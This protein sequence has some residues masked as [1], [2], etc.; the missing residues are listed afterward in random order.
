MPFYFK[1]KKISYFLNL[2]VDGFLLFA[3]FFLIYFTKRGHIHIEPTFINFIPV[4]ILSW[5]IS[6]IAGRKFKSTG[7]DALFTH[8]KPYILSIF[9]QIGLLSIILY[10]FKWY[11]LSR[12]IIFGSLGVFFLTEIFLLSG[13]YIYPF[14][15]KKGKSVE[16]NFSFY[17]FLLEFLL[18]TATFLGV[19]F[20]KRG[21]IELSDDYKAIFVILYF[22]WIFIGLSIHKFRVYGGRNYLKTLWPFFKATIIQ[23][24]ILSFFVFAFRILEY[25][26]LILFGSVLIFAAFE[27]VVVTIVY[28]YKKPLESDEASIDFFHAGI[29]SEPEEV[30]SESESERLFSG[31]YKITEAEIEARGFK[32][33]LEHVYL[34]KIPDVFNFLDETIELNGIDLMTAE[35]ISSGNP[36]NVEVLPDKFLSFFLNL[37]EVNDFRHINKYFMHVHDKLIWNGVFVSRFETYAKRRDR[38][39]RKYSYYLATIIYFFDFIWK[40]IFPKLPFFQKIYFAVTKGR[41]RVFSKTEALG[42]LH[43]CGFEIIA[44][45][46]IDNYIYFAV[47]KS[48]E[49]STEP[50]PSYGP[51]FK[52]KRSGK[53]DRSI[54][55]YKFRTMHPYAEYL[56]N[57]LISRNGYSNNTDKILDDFRLT[58]WGRFMRKYWL[59]EL[60]QIINFLKGDLSLIG[61]RPISKSGLQRFSPGFL[62][63]REKYKPGC[64]PPY[65]AL[66]MQSIDLYEE[67]EKIYLTEKEKQPFLTDVKYFYLAMYNILTNKIRS[68]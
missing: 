60:P 1:S 36:Y 48:K 61:V 67:S 56:Q 40:R 54:Y 62:E 25:S 29:L 4:Y 32:K 21:T 16:S 53:D 31:K 33:K 23:L 22:T 2:S 66:R 50:N 42:R 35:I 13:S 7:S 37:H 41:K 51:L 14:L 11:E 9:I 45:E 57:Y 28:L 39:F 58:G 43:F 46:E 18:I 19:Y 26:R 34:K 20:Y 64:I 68:A 5:F 52:M 38:I 6:T 65:V 3:S 59:D 12:F 8:L 30:K 49:C 44:L 63:I 17:F 27:Y 47:N 55:I 24:G 10:G 15:F